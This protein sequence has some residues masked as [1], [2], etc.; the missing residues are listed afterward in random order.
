MLHRASSLKSSS[1][2][3]P[4][5]KESRA[6]SPVFEALANAEKLLLMEARAALS[7]GNAAGALLA[8][9]AL[10]RFASSLEDEHSLA[11]AI[12]GNAGEEMILTVTGEV[13]SESRPWAAAP[14][15][16]DEIG[17][18]VPTGDSLE[19]LKR[20]LLI[21]QARQV[22]R[23]RK[24]LFRAYDVKEKES[25]FLVKFFQYLLWDLFDAKY[26]EQYLGC[27]KIIHTPYAGLSEASSPPGKAGVEKFERMVDAAIPSLLGLVQRFQITAS[28]KQIVRTAFELRKI[29]IRDGKYPA[30]RPAVPELSQADPFTGEPLAYKVLESGEL[31]LERPGAAELVEKIKGPEYRKALVSLTLPVPG[32]VPEVGPK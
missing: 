28:Q 29:G 2:P 30:E 8:V 32:P 24:D 3:F 20:E 1:Y 23:S 21:E 19:L 16:L 10:A 5:G 18:L 26:R 6:D 11:A 9:R 13:L 31:R 12:V 14:Q 17:A 4:Y 27:L 25:G 7:E 15:F 22:S